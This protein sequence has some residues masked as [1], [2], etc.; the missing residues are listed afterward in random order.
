MPQGE[1]CRNFPQGSPYCQVFKIAEHVLLKG[2]RIYFFQY[3]YAAKK[4]FCVM[5]RVLAIFMT[6]VLSKHLKSMLTHYGNFESLWPFTNLCFPLE[7][8]QNSLD[9]G[10]LWGTILRESILVS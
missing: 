8:T 3:F 5:N 1:R 9:F 2:F 7:A 6:A 4:L 10:T